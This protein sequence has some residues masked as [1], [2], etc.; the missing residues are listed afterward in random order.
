[1]RA[2][3]GVVVLLGGK[4]DTISCTKGAIVG[5]EKDKSCI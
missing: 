3:M 2:K 5:V 4:L 1:M